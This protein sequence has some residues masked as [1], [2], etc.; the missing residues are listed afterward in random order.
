MKRLVLSV[1]FVL[2]ALCGYSQQ[3]PSDVWHDGKLVLVNEDTLVGKL[4]YDMTRDIVQ[5]DIN[6]KLY[7]HGAKSIFY[8]KLYDATI[9][10][11]REFYVLPYGLVTSYKAPVIFEVL[12]EG[13]LSLLSREYVSTQSVQNNNP[14]NMG[15]FPSYQMDVLVYDY[16]FLDR[17]GNITPYTMK[18]RDLMNMLAKRQSQVTEYIKANKLKYDRR[19]DLIRIIAFYNALL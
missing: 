3:F 15:G 5:V 4:K 8:F 14:Y 11:F 12:V 16:Y 13:N 19:N 7:A 10:T 17:K 18:K 1:N 6:G 9:E 2:I